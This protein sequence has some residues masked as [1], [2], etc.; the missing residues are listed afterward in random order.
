[1]KKSLILCAALPL[2]FLASCNS[3]TKPKEGDVEPTAT[4]DRDPSVRAQD[5]ETGGADNRADTIP[6]AVDSTGTGGNQ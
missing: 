4:E 6:P 5:Y 3:A 1:M 2:F